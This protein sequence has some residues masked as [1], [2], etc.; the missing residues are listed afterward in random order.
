MSLV[1]VPM[2]SMA[3]NQIYRYTM[4][5]GGNR[6]YKPK[7]T[8]LNNLL[9]NTQVN[10]LSD[11]TRKRISKAV[12]WLVELSEEKWYKPP[13][14]EYEFKVRIAFLT[15]T[16][17]AAQRHCD[18]VITKECLNQYLVELR[19][20]HGVKNYV[21]KAEAQE[22]GNLHYHI[23]IDN[24]VD[25]DK[26][27]DRW[28]RITEKLGYITEFEKV[29]GHRDP[30]STDIHKTKDVKNLAAYLSA[31]MSKKESRRPI[32]GRDWGCSQT[33]SRCEPVKLI[34]GSDERSELFHVIKSKKLRTVQMDYGEIIYAKFDEWKDHG[35]IRMSREYRKYIAMARRDELPSKRIDRIKEVSSVMSS[36]AMI[37]LAVQQISHEMEIHAMQMELFE[38][39]EFVLPHPQRSVH[40][41]YPP[42]ASLRS[43]PAH[44]AQAPPSLA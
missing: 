39:A 34:E 2:M 43:T 40:H 44:V 22:N 28:N 27:R 5:E 1:A 9:H 21:W 15:V 13:G 41:A 29:N 17:P 23:A 7:Q 37:E 30:N 14:V 19:K 35:T 12:N 10:G 11:K 16:L 36:D 25:Y 24:P 38:P 20:Y 33:I 31:Y 3:P 42:A 26:A 6:H 8:S 4:W 32:C 18:K